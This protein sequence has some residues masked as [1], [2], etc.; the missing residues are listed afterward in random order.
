[1][2]T[3]IIG[4]GLAG[5][6]AAAYLARAGH[7]VTVFEKAQSIGGRAR[8]ERKQG[9]AFN[10][11]PH[12]LY[13]KGAGLRILRE[14]GVNFSGK[15]AG[16]DNAFAIDNGTKNTMPGGFVSLLTTGLLNLSAKLEAAKL[17][18]SLPKL[19]A[20]A[21]DQLTVREWL[22]REVKQPQV[23]QLVQALFRVST[24]ANDPDRQSAGAALRQLQMALD[25][26]VYYLDDGW[27]TLVTGLRAA[28]ETA[29]ATIQAEA[30][31]TAIERHAQGFALHRA[32]GERCC[33]F[34]QRQRR[35]RRMG[36]ESDSRARR[37]SGFSVDAL[38]TTASTLRPRH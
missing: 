5:L 14:L 21:Q 3:A 30:S 23:N 26:G 13:R 2:H 15:I 27:Q 34:S 18:A 1:M 11:G 7:A 22:A 10:F 38:A 20:A 4:G 17:L 35:A 37:M 32:N 9:F 19:D 25:G 33:R 29:G 36:E 8:T 24:Y 28:A 6:T 31:V 12:A 16:T